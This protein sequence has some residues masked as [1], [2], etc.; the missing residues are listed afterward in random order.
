M[1]SQDYQRGVLEESLAF[2]NVP[3][4]LPPS[5]GVGLGPVPV[6]K[7]ILFQN[8]HLGRR[9]KAAGGE[10]PLLAGL[11]GD[12][13][14]GCHATREAYRLR[15]IGSPWQALTSTSSVHHTQAT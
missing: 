11:G 8:D 12:R 14:V 3:R 6:N 10:H 2:A 4:S 5:E 9:A 13:G 7:T 1:V 15:S